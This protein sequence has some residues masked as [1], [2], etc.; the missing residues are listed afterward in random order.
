MIECPKCHQK[1]SVN[2]GSNICETCGLE[3]VFA[4]KVQ[5]NDKDSIILYEPLISFKK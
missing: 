4:V 5:I 2:Y 1:I 3:I